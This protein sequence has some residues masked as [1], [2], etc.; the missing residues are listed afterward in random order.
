[1]LMKKF[2]LFTSIFLAVAVI[3]LTNSG[4]A[5]V[6]LK[7]G[8]GS[9]SGYSGDPASGNENC[10][11]CHQGNTAQNVTGWITS[12]IPFT[13]YVPGS[14]YTITATAT[15]ASINKFGFQISPQNTSGNFLG[16]LVNTSTQ[17]QLSSNQKYITHT[18][19]GTSGT[20]SKTWSFNWTAPGASS[21]P[22]TFYGAFNLANG[23]FNATGDNIRLSTLIINE[24]T[25]VPVEENLTDK[26]FTIFP[27]PAGEKIYF[28]VNHSNMNSKYFVTDFSGKLKLIGN[29]ENGINIIDIS[30]IADGIYILHSDNASVSPRKFVK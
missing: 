1:M 20:G 8:S 16:T 28:E 11:S 30:S 15:D 25:S 27:N 2:I 26:T 24:D 29:I 23:N 3:A 12:N 7:N 10:T 4:G 13:G 9:P 5:D 17:T 22:V 19:S 21:G 14:T 6:F 18:S